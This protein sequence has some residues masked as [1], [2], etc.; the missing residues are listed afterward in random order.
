MGISMSDHIDLLRMTLPN[1]PKNRFEVM[2]T[3]Q[4]YVASQIFNDKRISIDGGTSVRRNVMLEPNGQA[5]F[6]MMFDTD[7]INVGFAQKQ[8]DVPWTLLE[9]KYAWDEAELLAQKGGHGYIDLIK[10]RV[11]E[12]LEAW[13][14]IIEEKFWST[15]TNSTDTL[16]PFG[17]PYYL[18]KLNSGVTTGGFSGYTI[19]F[20]DASTGTTCAG[21]DASTETKWRN[22]ADVY[23]TVDNAL[24]KKFRT[25]FRTTTFRPPSFIQNPGEDANIDRMI[26]TGGAVFDSLCDLADKRDDNHTPDELMGGVRVRTDGI[27]NIRIN[28]YPLLYV[29]YLD[30][31]TDVPIYCLDTAKMKA[32]VQ[33]GYWMKEK[34][35]M[36]SPFQH[37]VLVVYVDGKCCILCLNRRTSGFVLHKVTS[38]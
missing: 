6:R 26:C 36:V 25:A 3:Y 19:R 23:T 28:G 11:V 27:G 17:I 8:I 22:Y 31:D 5:R 15:P 2:W 1:L 10:S 35:P 20:G 34:E 37:T 30:S 12:A 38:A 29:P 18:N 16:V 32:V 21:I 9:T 33:E 7:A 14:T 4:Q 13:A 24:L